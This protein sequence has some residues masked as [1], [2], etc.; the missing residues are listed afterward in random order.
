MLDILYIIYKHTRDNITESMHTLFN[1]T[2]SVVCD[3]RMNRVGVSEE[4]EITLTAP[5]DS[6]RSLT[7]TYDGWQ[8]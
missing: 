1:Q 5:V 8:T 2:S 4:T 7:S 3:N 6:A